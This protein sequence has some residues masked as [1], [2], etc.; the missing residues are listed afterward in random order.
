MF[1]SIIDPLKTEIVANRV[2]YFHNT[3]A[4][5][6]ENIEVV[7]WACQDIILEQYLIQANLH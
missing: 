1:T 7:F 2:C 6:T 3:I 4:T 5:N